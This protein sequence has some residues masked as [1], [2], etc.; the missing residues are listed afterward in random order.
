M[1]IVLPVV[2]AGA[3]VAAYLVWKKSRSAGVTASPTFMP[4]A[5]DAS[6]ADLVVPTESGKPVDKTSGEWVA[7]PGD[8]K[9]LSGLGSYSRVRSASDSGSVDGVIDAMEAAAGV[10]RYA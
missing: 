1:G 10:G 6:V 7:K 5:P 8:T 9:S 3:G 4:E 2:V